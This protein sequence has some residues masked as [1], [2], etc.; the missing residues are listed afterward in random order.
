MRAGNPFK[1]LLSESNKFI[2]WFKG[3]CPYT[4]KF[5]GALFA[6]GF[7]WILSECMDSPLDK[8]YLKAKSLNLKLPEII[9]SKVAFS[10]L[11]ALEYLKRKNIMHRD[12]KPS[13]ILINRDC[14]IKL[15]D[16]G[17]SGFINNS[18]CLTV[19]GCC[20][21]MAPEKIMHT[22]PDRNEGYTIKSDIWSLG[23]SLYETANF[24][25]PV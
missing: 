14:T 4:V 17:I 12:V 8:F 15:C 3:D 11:S 13:N 6:E 16:F 23:I 10:V 20:P 5:Y 2:Y 24:K 19:T 21:Y 7:I 1:D 18:V 25:H 9:L 22:D